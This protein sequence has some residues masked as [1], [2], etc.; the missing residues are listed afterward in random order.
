MIEDHERIILSE[1]ELK[2]LYGYQVKK[3]ESA[4]VTEALNKLQVIYRAEQAIIGS[5]DVIYKFSDKPLFCLIKKLVMGSYQ[6][7]RVATIFEKCN[8]D[9][10]IIKQKGQKVYYQYIQYKQGGESWNP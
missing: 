1:Y 9:V 7:R 5:P 6:Y 4:N 2:E 8:Q 10:I 3:A